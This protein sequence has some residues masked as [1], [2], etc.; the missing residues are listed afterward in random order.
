[1]Q[2]EVLEFDEAVGYGTVRAT[3]GSEHFFHCT[4]IL[5]GSRSIDVGTAVEFEVVP[6]GCG[7][8]EAAAVRVVDADVSG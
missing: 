2:G 7:R 6:G 5:D 3:D 1:V 4:A 8:W